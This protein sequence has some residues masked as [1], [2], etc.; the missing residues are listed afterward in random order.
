MHTASSCSGKQAENVDYSRIY[1]RRRTHRQRI[2]RQC[3]E[4]GASRTRSTKAWWSD[5]GPRHA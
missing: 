1:H 5:K 2:L 4:N 3:V